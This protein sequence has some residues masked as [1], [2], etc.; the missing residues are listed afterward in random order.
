M[1][2]LRL[3]D[4]TTSKMAIDHT[5]LI[6]MSLLLQCPNIIQNRVFYKEIWTME[7]VDPQML[8]MACT[9]MESHK[10]AYQHKEHVS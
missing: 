2:Q 5:A 3:I 6:H 1:T 8:Y 4:A 9:T 10:E 7:P